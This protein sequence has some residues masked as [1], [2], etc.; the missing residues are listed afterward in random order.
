MHPHVRHL[1]VDAERQAEVDGLRHDRRMVGVVC[2]VARQELQGLARWE[3]LRGPTASRLRRT[4]TPVVEMQVW[5]GGCGCLLRLQRSISEG[6]GLNVP[7]CTQNPIQP[8]AKVKRA[9][10]HPR[11][12]PTTIPPP[13]QSTPRK[14]SDAPHSSGLPIFNRPLRQHLLPTLPHPRQLG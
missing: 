2:L 6:G 3:G 12:P 5:Q 1:P 13:T 7:L 9:P 10:T 11:T 14:P 8:K 4:V